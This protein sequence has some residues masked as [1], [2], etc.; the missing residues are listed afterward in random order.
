[1]CSGGGVFG[2]RRDDEDEHRR[3]RVWRML[4]KNMEKCYL[5]LRN[6]KAKVVVGGGVWVEPRAFGG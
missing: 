3:G 1:M 4:V 6:E 5:Y 2:Q